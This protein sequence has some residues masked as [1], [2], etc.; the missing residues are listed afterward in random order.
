MDLNPCV[1][2]PRLDGTLS[3]YLLMSQ[4][5]SHSQLMKIHLF[6]DCEFDANEVVHIKILQ[7]AVLQT[8]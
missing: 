5:Y 2:V 1:Y 6:L 8:P 4:V 3:A 7:C